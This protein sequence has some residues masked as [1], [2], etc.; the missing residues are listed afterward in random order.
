MLHYCHFNWGIVQA[1]EKEFSG[2]TYIFY[3]RKTIICSYEILWVPDPIYSEYKNINIWL[4]QL[5]AGKSISPMHIVCRVTFT[6][7]MIP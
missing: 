4:T 5:W 3:N 6:L 1:F 7:N 2:I